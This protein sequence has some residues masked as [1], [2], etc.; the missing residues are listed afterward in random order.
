MNLSGFPTISGGAVN[1]DSTTPLAALGSIHADSRGRLYRYVLAGVAPLVPGNLLQSP[2]QVAVHGQLT[3]TAA[4]AV[5]AKQI[6]VTLGAAAAAENLYAEGLA[7]IDTTPGE[8]Y[9]YGISGHAAVLSGGIATINLRSD[10]AV[11]VALTTASRV[12]LTPHP[13][14]GVIQTPVTTLTGAV[15][16]V[17]VYPIAAGR[18]GWVGVNGDFPTLIDGTPAVG[19]A[20]SAPGAAPGAA[21]INSSTL[22]IVGRA[23]VTG[24][25]GKIQPVSLNLL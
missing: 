5:G 7:S 3:P 17:A 25:T 12:T 19:M 8:G 6:I 22:L 10:D 24:V 9:S 11:Q 15:V 18:Y 23:L 2:A 21:A 13:C 20:L 14:R 4:V 16:G 1:S